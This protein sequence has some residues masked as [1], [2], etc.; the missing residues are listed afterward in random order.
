MKLI[1]GG[2]FQGKKAAAC[3]RYH[4]LDEEFEDGTTCELERIYTCR[5]VYHFHEYVRRLLED[6]GDTGDLAE[7]LYA[8]NPHIVIICNELGYGVV[9]IQ[10]FDREYRETVGRICCKIAEH[11]EEVIRIVSGLCM[12]IKHA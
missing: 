4:I 1:V 3:K 7:R 10:P 11:S 2:A 6:T 12:V 9:P 5:G 8:A